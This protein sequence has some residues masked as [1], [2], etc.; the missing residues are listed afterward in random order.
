MISRSLWEVTLK[1]CGC[2]VEKK[3]TLMSLKSMVDVRKNS[4]RLKVSKTFAALALNN[5]NCFVLWLLHIC[6]QLNE[7]YHLIIQS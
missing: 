3:K 4:R 5:I 6:R 7:Q 1:I 2:I